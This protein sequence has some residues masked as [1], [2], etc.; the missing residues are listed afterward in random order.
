MKKS[1]LLSGIIFGIFS[2]LPFI[3]FTQ[4]TV[5]LRGDSIKIYKVGGNAELILENATR[6][7][8]GGY[9]KNRW[10]G[11]MEVDYAVDSAYIS[12]TDLVLVRGDG[13]QNVVIPL[14]SFASQNLQQVTDV[15]Q[16]TDD[17]IHA[18]GLASPLLMSD[19]VGGGTDYEIIVFPD[20]Q[21]MIRFKPQYSRSMFQWL[22]DSADY[23]NVKALLQVGDITDWNTQAEWDTVAVQLGLFTTAQPDIPYLF[24]P[25]NHDY[26]N[27]FTPSGRDATRYNTFFDAAHFSG[28]TFYMGNY[29][30]T[31]ENY[32]IK[33]DVGNRKYAA[34]GLEFLPRDAVVDWANDLA[35]SLA[36]ADPY[37]ELMVVTHA[38][39]SQQG[40]MA[41]DTSVYSSDYYGMTA[42]NSG[43]ELWDNFIKLH[44]NIRFVFSGH[45][46]I[47]DT[48]ARRGL[49]DRITASGINGNLIHQIFVN[50]QD[51]N[52]W[53]DGYFMR[54]KFNTATNDVGVRFWS[55][56]YLND[57]TTNVGYTIE[58]PTIDVKSAMAVRGDLGVNGVVR[59]ETELKSGVLEKTGV[60]Y[61][62]ADHAL[63]TSPNITYNK[64]ANGLKI[65]ATSIR[66]VLHLQYFRTTHAS[67]F[68]M[69]PILRVTDSLDRTALDL[70]V[71]YYYDTTNG[72]YSSIFLGDSSNTERGVSEVF[73]GTFAGQKGT[74]GSHSTLVG[75]EAGRYHLGHSLQ[76]AIG[77]RALWKLTSGGSNTAVGESAFRSATTASWNTVMGQSAASAWL[78]GNDNSMYGQNVG[79]NNQGGS[80]NALFGSSANANTS[81]NAAINYNSAFGIRALR[82]NNGDRSSGFG[83]E[84]GYNSWGAGN[85]FLGHKAGTNQGAVE[86]RLFINNDS[87]TS[88]IEG[89][90]AHDSVKVNGKL[91]ATNLIRLPS[92]SAGLG[93]IL[94]ALDNQG[95]ADWR[96]VDAVGGSGMINPM[97]TLG[98]MIFQFDGAPTRL[99]I[100]DEDDVLTV[101][102]GVPV[103]KPSSAGSSSIT[104]GTTPIVTGT[105]GAL[106]FEG[107][108]NVVQQDASN[109]FWNNTTKRLGIGTN[110]PSQQITVI[111]N[112]DVNALGPIHVQSVGTNITGT[113]L[114]ID[115][116]SETGGNVYSFLSTGVSSTPQAGHFAFY[117][118]AR[119]YVA[120]FK[121]NGE[122]WFGNANPTPGSDMGDQILQVTG[123]GIFTDDVTV[124]TE[125]YGSGWNGS[126][127]VPTKDA[128]YDKVESMIY[129]SANTVLG[130][131]YEDGTWGGSGVAVT[132]PTGTYSFEAFLFVDN[133]TG[134]G[135]YRMGGTAT[136]SF[137]TYNIT[138]TDNSTDALKFVS[139]HTSLSGSGD[140]VTGTWSGVVRMTGTVTIS[141]GGTLQA[142]H[143]NHS[144]PGTQTASA[145]TGTFLIVTKIN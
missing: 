57:D 28:K 135:K 77:R 141:S 11:R 127:E 119:G 63:E 44:P 107:S 106:L 14:A 103:W 109:L 136:A 94:M 50:Y 100:G 29:G 41:T 73:I 88:L 91:I 144:T 133:T 66:P 102:S 15:G 60:I 126:N 82:E 52:N 18:R 64:L 95:N 117:T 78:T 38:H 98:D 110:N 43:Q 89:W 65:K 93:K 9:L 32:W 12:G 108:G 48:W 47:P 84:A 49:Q 124:P 27:G 87:A 1:V 132:L 143:T 85:L 96:T 145:E 118:P 16:I 33:W 120:L 36:T 83:Y 140:G 142:E 101:E 131:A 111:G 122:V 20:I 10:N 59:A 97:T 5:L 42:D 6:T 8:T 26:G 25:G 121:N 113:A 99:G 4:S 116:R 137:T 75:T 2:A 67:G 139:R 51:D 115:A 30:G 13:A 112:T 61:T 138:A 58:S 90:F 104:V 134:G 76:T 22:A 34:I 40:E 130:I 80:Y 56:S 24:V 68:T 79:G 123:G 74:G 35:D 53:G 31:N 46:L 81:T 129:R 55:A 92:D 72:Y 45:F 70:K 128:V 62:G 39:I 125:T 86:N 71:N 19:T 37:R 17:T 114:S 54:L 3:S 105:V 23:Y 7:R 21:N 69:P